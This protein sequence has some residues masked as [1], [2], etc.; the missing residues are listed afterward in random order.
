MQ[1][2]RL[3]RHELDALISL[4]TIEL[5]RDRK[6]RHL[7]PGMRMGLETALVKLEAMPRH[8]LLVQTSA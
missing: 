7:S 5:T 8:A 2:E 4:V 6:E 3:K 1:P